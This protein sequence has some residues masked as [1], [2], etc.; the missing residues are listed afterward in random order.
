[1]SEANTTNIIIQ[2]EPVEKLISS[3]IIAER[4]NVLNIMKQNGVCGDSVIFSA[5]MAQ[6]LEPSYDATQM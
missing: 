1:M 2:A 3:A 4:L 5:N 6:M